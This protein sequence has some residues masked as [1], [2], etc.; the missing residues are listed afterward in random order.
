MSLNH[1][2]YSFLEFSFER[3]AIG[4]MVGHM[5]TEEGSSLVIISEDRL[6]VHA[7]CIGKS[8]E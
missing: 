7:A 6:I 3:M 8:T 2:T 4:S 1:Y 5:V